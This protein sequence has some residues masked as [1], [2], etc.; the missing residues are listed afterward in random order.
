MMLM[1]I[2]MGGDKGAISDSVVFIGIVVAISGN[3]NVLDLT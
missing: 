3:G 2:W 1:L